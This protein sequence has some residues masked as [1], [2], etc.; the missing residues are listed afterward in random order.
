MEL[1]KRQRFIFTVCLKSI[2]RE[3]LQ[4]L[5]SEF[6]LDSG[7]DEEMCYVITEFLFGSDD[8]RGFRVTKRVSLGNVFVKNMR[9]VD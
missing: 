6:G 5:C 2:S 4:A 3:R 1:S 7:S 9:L 8:D